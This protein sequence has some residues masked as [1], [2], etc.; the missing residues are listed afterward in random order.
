MTLL[1]VSILLVVFSV[2]ILS[3]LDDAMAYFQPKVESAE[4]NA[5][6]M[7]TAAYTI[8]E[9]VDY[10]RISKGN[11]LNNVLISHAENQS[12]KLRQL[13]GNFLS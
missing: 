13:A 9:L 2:Y 10:L 8:E 11:D 1:V 5:M 4:A 12:V 7:I 3:K 6:A